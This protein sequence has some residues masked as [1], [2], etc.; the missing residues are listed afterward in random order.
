[1]LERHHKIAFQIWLYSVNLTKEWNRNGILFLDCNPSFSCSSYWRSSWTA[2]MPFSPCISNIKLVH[3][4]HH[5][6]VTSLPALS[7]VFLFLCRDTKKRKIEN[8][9]LVDFAEIFDKMVIR[10]KVVKRRIRARYL[11]DIC[12]IFW[13]I[14][15]LKV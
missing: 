5:S 11:S 9:F 13:L 14:I 12:L 1:M 6:V 4:V 3:F 2:K 10:T 15:A 8:H 7:R